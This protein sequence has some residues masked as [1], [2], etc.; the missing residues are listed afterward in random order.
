MTL[1]KTK[2]F[3]WNKILTYKYNNYF[4]NPIYKLS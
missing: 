4:K 2:I 1:I 3:Y